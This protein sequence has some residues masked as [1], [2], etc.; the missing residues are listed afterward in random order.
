[1]DT[2]P[3]GIGTEKIVGNEAAVSSLRK[4]ANDIDRGIK[5][6]PVMLSGPSGIGK[7]FSVRI[8]AEEHGWNII[9]LNASDYR[10]KDAIEK[11]TITATQS[12]G[13]F[14]GRNLILLDEVDELSARHDREAGPAIRR[15]L[16][17]SRSPVIMTANNRWGLKIAFLRGVVENIEFKRLAQQDVIEVLEAHA[18]VRHIK[19]DKDI[20]QAIA[21]RSNGDARSA[22][23]DLI[24]LDGAPANAIESIWPRDRKIEIFATLDKIFSSN[25]LTA[26]LSAVLNS[27][28]QSDMLVKWIDENL[29][30]RYKEKGNLAEAYAA[31]SDATMYS[32]RASRKQYYTYWRYRNVMMA[33]GVALS[34][35]VSPSQV[36]RYVFPSTIMHL[37]KTKESRGKDAT[38]ARKLRRMVHFS[39][40]RIRGWEMGMIA[41]QAKLMVATDGEEQVYAMLQS[42]FGL[43]EK[44]AE[45]LVSSA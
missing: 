19:V 23:N 41:K 32:S 36:E 13:L 17:S 42:G 4:Y 7:S 18:N 14:G 28:V 40:A 35:T 3:S 37:S 2:S 43:D 25:T 22:I 27:D 15:L 12:K 21:K 39:T 8:V 31:L 38:V 33:S 20:M 30:K 9:E 10:N 1:M 6:K 16:Q 34:K 5:R 24:A 45:W 11:I 26:P 29:P 44:E